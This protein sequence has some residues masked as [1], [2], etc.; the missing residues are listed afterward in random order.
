LQPDRARL[1]EDASGLLILSPRCK[2][3]AP[4]ADLIHRI[5]FWTSRSRPNRGDM[6][7][8]FALARE[9]AAL[10]GK[11]LKTTAPEPKI[12]TEKSGVTYLRRR[13]NVRFSRCAK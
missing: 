2:I 11:N 13:A 3:G 5:R 9:I 8:H 12:E 7:S 4:I 1:G 6:L 10:S